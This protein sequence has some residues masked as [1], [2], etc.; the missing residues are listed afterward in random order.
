V[1]AA[2][3]NRSFILATLENALIERINASNDYTALLA[4][5]IGLNLDDLGLRNADSEPYKSI[6]QLL[7]NS[8]VRIFDACAS[9]LL[10][11]LCPKYVR[12]CIDV[13]FLGKVSLGDLIR[14]H[15]PQSIFTEYHY[16][17]VPGLY[18]GEIGPNTLSDLCRGR[19][20]EAQEDMWA[21]IRALG[22]VLLP[23]PTPWVQKLNWDSK[24]TMASCD[25]GVPNPDGPTLFG[26][27]LV[28]AF[29]HERWY[30]EWTSRSS[31]Q[32]SEY[33]TPFP[34]YLYWV[35]LARGSEEPIDEARILQ[36]LTTSR[37][38]PEQQDFAQ[39]WARRQISI[40]R[41]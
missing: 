13:F 9:Q 2:K 23:I 27:F 41:D 6:R 11:T 19:Q 12:T 31:F 36:E 10:G 40:F 24:W 15:G 38:S 7:G 5:E 18:T 34:E 25:R 30:E 21:D 20:P 39:K 4:A 17:I 1:Y 28:L 3:D 8:V 32:S 33:K 37:F 35:F 26:I 16:V 14:W 29:L 22:E